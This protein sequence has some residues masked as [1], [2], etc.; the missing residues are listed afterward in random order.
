MNSLSLFYRENQLL[1]NFIKI[2]NNI[3][4]EIN[5]KEPIV[6]QLQR[7]SLNICLLRARMIGKAVT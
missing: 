1:V 5:V 3:V 2:I 4:T 7:N 6:G